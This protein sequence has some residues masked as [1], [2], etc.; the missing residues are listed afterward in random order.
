[1]RHMRCVL[2]LFSSVSLVR[3]PCSVL[4]QDLN[5]E[6]RGLVVACLDSGLN[7]ESPLLKGIKVRNFDLTGEGPRDLNGHG[8]MVLSLLMQ[9]TAPNIIREILNIKTVDRDGKTDAIRLMN[10]MRVAA[11]NGAS[12]IGL[13]SGVWLDRS[14]AV[15]FCR[16]LRQFSR[17]HPDIIITEAAGNIEEFPKKGKGILFP[18]H[19]AS[20]DVPA[21]FQVADLFDD[22]L[23]L[24]QEGK[25]KEAGEV[26]LQIMLQLP[27]EKVES[28]VLEVNKALLYQR[29]VQG[30][31]P[32]RKAAFQDRVRASIA[33]YVDY[34]RFLRNWDLVLADEI[35]SE[36]KDLYRNKQFDEAAAKHRRALEIHIRYK[37]DSEIAIDHLNLGFSIL[38]TEKYRDS[39]AEFKEATV[40]GDA[41]KDKRIVAYA[42][43]GLAVALRKDGRF[44]DARKMALEAKKKFEEAEF[45]V[46]D[47]DTWLKQLDESEK[48]F[49][50]K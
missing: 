17:R 18:Q 14:A 43:F 34:D 2:L 41:V 50:G 8:M 20:V 19:A 40:L 49:A 21:T 13:T 1:M 5:L 25:G 7:G 38:Q 26:T 6:P 29:L 10:G 33:K 3:F 30:V 9:S 22:L 46:V 24:V 15:P 27:D 16:K 23:W 35:R 32:S 37:R 11:D 47:I 31:D 44:G 36:G 48:K 42:Q 39:Q 45:T 12:M 28:R 4:G